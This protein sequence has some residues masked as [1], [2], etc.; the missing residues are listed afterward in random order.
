MEA[1][2]LIKQVMDRFGGRRAAA[3]ALGITPQAI[4][5]WVTSGRIPVERVLDVERR[6]SI[7]RYVLRPDVYGDN[8]MQPEVSE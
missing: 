1:H 4:Q 6:T 7:S 8:P 5:K 3:A 2:Y